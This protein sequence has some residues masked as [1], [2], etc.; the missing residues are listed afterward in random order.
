M[1]RLG[2]LSLQVPTFLHQDHPTDQIPCMV[3][4]THESYQIHTGTTEVLSVLHGNKSSFDGFL[5]GALCKPCGFNLLE[6]RRA[7]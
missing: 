6:G 5:S 2:T 7:L 4:A 3:E 1:Y